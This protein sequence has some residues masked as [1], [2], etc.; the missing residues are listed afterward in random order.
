MFTIFIASVLVASVAIFAQSFWQWCVDRECKNSGDWDARM[1]DIMGAKVAAVQNGEEIE[2]IYLKGA[3]ETGKFLDMVEQPYLFIQKCNEAYWNNMPEQYLLLDGRLPQAEGEIVLEKNYFVEHP[4]CAIGNKIILQNGI[5]YINEQEMDFLSIYQDGERF[6]E[7]GQVEYTLVGSIDIS[8]NSAYH[9]Y[10]AYGYM[11]EVSED[12]KYIVYLKF[13]NPRK[14]FKLMPH[15]LETCG[16]GID[17]NGNYYVE[18]N[19]NLL[20]LYAV[21]DKRLY[22]KNCKGNAPSW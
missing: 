6:I 8:I 15:I 21:L 2:Q 12:D 13:R 16:A 19:K 18:Y 10:A 7:A 17:E 1:L 14:T 11:G 20:R 5:R 22:N 3:Y 4:E 9:G